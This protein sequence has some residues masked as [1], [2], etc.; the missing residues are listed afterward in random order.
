MKR[1]HRTLVR[2]VAILAAAAV[3]VPAANAANPGDVN[4]AKS[5]LEAQFGFSPSRATDWTTGVCSY[6]DKPSSCYLTAPQAKAQSWAQA[7]AMG[8][9]PTLSVATADTSQAFQWGDAGIG[10]GAAL[11]LVLVLVGIGAGRV[12]RNR[13]RSPIHA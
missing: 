2:I 11:G 6:V 5:V 12:L 4:L 9:I 10:A 13:R 7:R 3:L 1:S 8:A